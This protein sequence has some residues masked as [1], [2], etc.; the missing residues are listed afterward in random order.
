MRRDVNPLPVIALVTAVVGAAAIVR[1]AVD[2]GMLSLSWTDK[3]FAN[4]WLAATL[5][6]EGRVNDV[7]GP[8]ATYLAAMRAVFG[9]DYPWHSWSYPPHYLLLM[10]PLALLP[11]KAALLSFLTATFL[12]F[13]A[14]A[15]AACRQPKG[16][17]LLLLLPPVLTNAYVAQN[18]FLLSAL[19]LAGLALRD[20]R[21][22]V[23]GL[24]F[25]LLTI[26]PQ[27]GVLLPLLLLWERQWVT[28]AS[29]TLTAVLFAALSAAVFGL[30]AWSGYITQTM[31]YQTW[32]MTEKT[33]LFLHMMPTLFGSVRSLSGDAAAAF[34][35][36]LPFA[37]AVLALYLMSLVRL[38]RP[39]ARA[40]ATLF[41]TT[42]AVPY[43][44]N[45][46]LV[47]LVAGAV[48]WSDRGRMSLSW[49]SALAVLAV[50]PMLMPLFG[51]SGWPIAP[52]AILPV[53][54]G[55]LAREGTFQRLTRRPSPA[56]P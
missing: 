8:H 32:V 16:W 6:L 41:A 33:G 13:L 48:F 5:A 46:D 55:F 54:L 36:H 19:L 27:L 50:V 39:E 3:D 44:L 37:A 24:C 35:I 18:G 10:L 14:A 11:Y 4:Y 53:W 23:A 28:I 43:L 15:R 1:V 34:A 51:L 26:K 31:P 7:F 25:G 47:A 30:G 21:P 42:L 12:L 49:G 29:A 45:Y 40:A 22:V 56:T 2:P 52:L 38:A 17:Q 9:A 20:R